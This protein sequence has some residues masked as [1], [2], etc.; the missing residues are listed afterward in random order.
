MAVH[1]FSCMKR[2]IPLA[3][4]GALYAP[5]Y[6]ATLQLHNAAHEAAPQPAASSARKTRAC[7]ELTVKGCGPPQ[8]A[9][10][11]PMR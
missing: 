2:T 8:A 7:Q 4:P 6:A 3:T 11:Y 9:G 10:M 1:G 5:Q